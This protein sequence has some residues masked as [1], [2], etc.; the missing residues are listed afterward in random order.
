MIDYLLWQKIDV[1]YSD[2]NVFT[3]ACGSFFGHRVFMKW[4]DP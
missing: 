3:Q 2:E 4:V 1:K